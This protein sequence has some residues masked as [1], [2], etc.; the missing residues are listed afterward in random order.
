MRILPW[1]LMVVCLWPRPGRAQLSVEVVLDQEQYL[2][3]ESLTAKVRV[4]NRSGQAIHLGTDNEWLTFAVESVEQASPGAVPR[5]GEVPV[6]GE[7]S[8]ESAKVAIR[9]VDLTPWFDLSQP[10]RYQVSA[11]VRVKEWNQEVSS[12]PRSFE[13]VRGTK[14]W[15]LEFGV[16]VD[17]G[18]P[19]SRKFILQQANYRKQLKLYLRLTDGSEQR[20]LRIFPIGPLVSFSQTEAQVDKSSYLHVLFQA[21]A[22][23]F[24]FCVVSPD[25]DLVL[26]QTYDYA[27]TRP[28]LRS[29]PEGRIYVAGG[30]RHLSLTDIPTPSAIADFAAAAATNST[31][32]N[33]PATNSPASVTNASPATPDKDATEKNNGKSR[34]K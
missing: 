8:L 22:R 19:E 27:P 26:R 33:S 11:T 29:N 5:I 32:T 12:R 23:S 20:V 13:V 7:F 2:R 31:A 17:G 30:L 34:K 4:T 3:D 6:R 15:E 10:G 21:G 28:T 18:A 9:Q 25:G 16:P 24:L 14:L 1:L